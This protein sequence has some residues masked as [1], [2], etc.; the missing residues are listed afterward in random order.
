[1]KILPLAGAAVA[2]IVAIFVI[3]SVV[4][5]NDPNKNEVRVAFFANISHAVPIVGMENGYYS[6]QLGET[7][8]KTKIVDSGPEAIEALFANSIDIAYVGPAPFVNGYVKS[9]GEGIKIISGAANNGASFVVQKDSTISGPSDLAGKKIAAPFVGN[10]QDVSLRNYLAENGLKPAEKGGNV[11]IYNIANAEIN[12][13]FAKGEIDAAW[14]PEPTATMLVENLGGKRLFQEEELWPA[15]RFP[16]VVLIGRADY[17]EKHPEV[18]QK[19]LVAHQQAIDW[20]NQNPQQTESTYIKFYK[21]H[22]GK[23]LKENIVHNSFSNIV[24]T[25]EVDVD[26]IKIFAERAYSLGYLGRDGYN[27]DD[28]YADTIEEIPWQS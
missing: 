17:I 20:I 12:T 11:I 6:D 27:L 16:S 5:A 13:I 22:T 2:A 28:I 25:S 19:W 10:T 1:M 23:T 3:L 26:A 4:S 15:K 14:V 21:S 24:Y 8:I 7:K 18:I 9:G